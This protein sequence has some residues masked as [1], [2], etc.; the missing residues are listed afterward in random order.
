MAKLNL[1]RPLAFFDLETTGINIVSDR[2]V[3]I[4]ILKIFPDGKQESKTYRI[5]PTIPI[6]DAATKIHGI[7]DI[8]VQNAPTFKQLAKEIVIFFDDCDLAGYNINRFDIPLLMEEFLRVEVDF[9]MSNRKFID[10][11]AIFHKKEERTLS[12]AYKFYCSRELNNAHSAEADTRATFEILESQLDRYSD[13]KNEIEYLHNYSSYSRK[14]DFMG[15]FVYNDKNIPVFNFGKHTG[16]AVEYVFK[17][18]PQYY[19]WMMKGDFSL[20]IKK[21]I[22]EIFQKTKEKTKQ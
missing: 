9:D 7:K 21:I 8:D 1:S 17:I 5:N 22:T 14:V 3:E 18:E 16:K 2:I 10:V 13:L 6:P 20:H 11:Q 15:K 12:A 4:S 19:N